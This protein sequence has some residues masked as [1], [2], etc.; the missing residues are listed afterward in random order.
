MSL[1]HFISEKRGITLIGAPWS[2]KTTIWKLL[3]PHLSWY[4]FHDMDDHGLQHPE[5]WWGKDWVVKKLVKLWDQEFLKAEWQFVLDNYGLGNEWRKF[6]FEWMLF[7]STGSLPL[8]PK[9]MQHVRDRTLVI[10]VDVPIDVLEKRSKPDGRPDGNTRIV[11]MNWERPQFCTLR[12]TLEYRWEIYKNSCDFLLPYMEENPT[13]TVQ[14]II[15]T[16]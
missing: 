5:F 11:G 9:A 1:D 13:D 12:E 4:N 14:R 7:S 2:W 6:S 16:L 10:L 8:S 15:N 3:E